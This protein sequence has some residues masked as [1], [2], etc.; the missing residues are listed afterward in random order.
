MGEKQATHAYVWGYNN[1]GELGLGHAGRVF[2]PRPAELPPGLVDLQ[3][4]ANFT[5]ALTSSGRIWTWG[6]N[7]H[8]QLGDGSRTARR[9]PRQIRLPDGHRAA[10][11]AAGTDH[12]VVV[13]TRGDVVTWGRNHRGQ[14]GTGDRDDRLAPR[15]V[16]C[17]TVRKVAAGDGVCA[18]ITSTGRLL[19]WGRNGQ[20]Q[21]AQRGAVPAG[22]DVLRPK[23]ARQVDERVRAVDAGLR[24]LVVL[25]VEGEVLGFGVDA[26]G[27]PVPR[28]IAVPARWGTVRQIAAGE[29]HTL[30]LTS[31]GHVVVWGANDLGQLGVGNR[32]HRPS[33]VRVELPGARGDATSI[34]T[35][36]RH[37]LVLTDRHEV[38]AWGE[39]RF[40]AVGSGRPAPE[41]TSYLEPQRVPLRGVAVSRLAGGGYTS[42]V[43]VHRGPAVRLELDPPRATGQPGRDVR[44]RIRTV[45]AFGTDL[46]PAPA[47]VEVVVPGGTTRHTSRAGTAVAGPAI[48]TYSVVARAGHLIGRAT[49]DVSKGGKR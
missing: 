1:T 14:L 38:F 25:T 18:A 36:H 43:L 37:S 44:Y 42:A 15:Q 19:T 8:G 35:G 13:T 45:D 39:G 40:G 48:G 21:L 34:R 32:S 20:D 9:E 47:G 6:G 33:P 10:A 23:R 29:D 17:E 12:V 7:E 49:L 4:G 41:G 31:R 3:G 5:V 16:R 28:R 46:G 22:H 27:Q 24:H 2:S 30:A 26:T 11:I